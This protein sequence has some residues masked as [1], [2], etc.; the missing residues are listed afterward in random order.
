MFLKNAQ[1][2]KAK[3]P[4]RFEL[5]TV[6]WPELVK[7]G[8]QEAAGLLGTQGPARIWVTLPCGTVP[9]VA[10]GWLAMSPGPCFE[11]SCFP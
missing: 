6:T 10:T 9:L 3:L 11:V 2:Q 4:R 7:E 1:L 5:D 8:A